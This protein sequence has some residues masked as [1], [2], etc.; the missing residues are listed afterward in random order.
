M[1]LNVIFDEYFKSKTLLTVVANI[2]I[3]KR[4]RNKIGA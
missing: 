2:V 1:Y 4:Y 3:L